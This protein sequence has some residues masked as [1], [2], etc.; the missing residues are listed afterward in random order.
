MNKITK[1]FRKA[2][3]FFPSELPTGTTAFEAYT[4]HIL[5]TYELPS[6]PG[7]RGAIFTMILHLPATKNYCS[8][9]FFAKSVKKSMSNQVAYELL[10]KAKEESSLEIVHSDVPKQTADETVNH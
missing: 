3:A 9:R 10:R 4:K 2:C 8:K 7:Y 5:D 6:T 1:L